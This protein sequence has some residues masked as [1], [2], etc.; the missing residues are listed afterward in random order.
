MTAS[1]F[2]SPTTGRGEEPT[3]WI[4]GHCSVGLEKL[5]KVAM[6]YSGGVSGK[7][8]TAQLLLKDGLPLHRV[9]QQTLLVRILVITVTIIV[10]AT[11]C[12]GSK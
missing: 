11:W 4:A 3:E 5:C 12:R 6:V 2:S 7:T 9:D 10:H 1:S 8:N